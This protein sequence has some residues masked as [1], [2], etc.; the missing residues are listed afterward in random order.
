[1]FSSRI[2][3]HA[4]GY[5]DWLRPESPSDWASSVNKLA[6]AMSKLKST[7]TWWWPEESEALGMESFIPF[8]LAVWKANTLLVLPCCC[9]QTNAEL[10]VIFMQMP[11]LIVR[12]AKLNISHFVLFCL[13]GMVLFQLALSIA[14]FPWRFYDQ[15]MEHSIHPQLLA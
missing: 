7:S 4:C 8:W 14:F 2:L 10:C 12:S 1:M 11:H 15:L 13:E 5:F 9:I 6:A 3:L